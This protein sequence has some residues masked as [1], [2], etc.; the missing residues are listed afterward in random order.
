MNLIAIL[1]YF[2]CLVVIPM[3]ALFIL[4][5]Y[6]K[7]HFISGNVIGKTHDGVEFVLT[8]K[9]NKQIYYINTSETRWNSAEIGSFFSMDKEDHYRLQAI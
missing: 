8:I 4:L 9:S 7:T 3:T 1:I 5:H 2:V 6:L